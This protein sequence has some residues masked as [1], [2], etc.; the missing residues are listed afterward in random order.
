MGKIKN[1]NKKTKHFRSYY[2]FWNYDAV[3]LVGNNHVNCLWNHISWGNN[4]NNNIDKS[5]NQK[6]KKKLQIPL[7]LSP[8]FLQQVNYGQQKMQHKIIEREKL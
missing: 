3:S 8:E 7:I 5:K 2:V 1:K 4:R 6:T